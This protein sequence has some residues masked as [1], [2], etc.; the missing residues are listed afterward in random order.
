MTKWQSRV[1]GVVISIIAFVMVI[2]GG[3]LLAESIIHE[4]DVVVT[5]TRIKQDSNTIPAS[6]TVITATDIKEGAFQTVADILCG[7]AG[8]YVSDM[9]GNARRCSVDI[10]GFGERAAANTL[11]LIDGRAINGIDMSGVD[12]TNIPLE[13]IARIEIIRGGASVIYGN[14]AVSGVINIITKKNISK[15]SLATD[16]SYGSYNSYKQSLSL[17]GSFADY[18]YLIDGS[19]NDGDGYRR[20]SYFRNKTA[21]LTLNYMPKEGVFAWQLSAGLKEDAYGLPGALTA[22][23]DPRE[24][25]NPDDYAKTKEQYVHFV[26]SWK[27][28]QNLNFSIE[29]DYREQEQYADFPD[30]VW[31]WTIKSRINQYAISPKFDWYIEQGD[32]VHALTIGADYKMGQFHSLK[33]GT[34]DRHMREIGY[35]VYDKISLSEK[36]YLD[37]GYRRTRSKNSYDKFSKN[38]ANIDSYKAGLTYAYK[39]NS[40]L[41]FSFDRSFRTQLLDELGGPWGAGLP[42]SPQINTQYQLG[43][44]HNFNDKLNTTLSLFQIKTQNEMF[45]NPKIGW[46]G[47]NTSYGTTKRKGVELELQYKPIQTITISTNYT[48][49][50][51]HLKGGEFSG[52]EIPAVPTHTASATINY[53]PTNQFNITLA[54]RWVKSHPSTSDWENNLTPIATYTVVD[55]KAN[56]QLNKNIT[57]Y[58]GVKNIFSEEYEQYVTYGRNLYPAPECN[59][60]VGIKY[61]KEF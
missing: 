23:D 16:I 13:N 39:E 45:F 9:L 18:S 46:A 2:G 42:L 48:Y 26:P 54:G 58:A 30:P 4:K 32:I 6:V 19:Y 1:S 60:F 11:V 22:N 34:D 12:W 44:K 40:K 8:I 37:L 50:N 14:K 43:I 27:I 3:N 5:A 24:S 53:Q 33:N 47:E 52:N 15:H 51:A 35:F 36:L 29:F 56:Y 28:N 17:M 38:I 25:K 55:I 10:R 31:P 61:Y 20:N 49:M 59:Y 41:F 7:R 57:I 21:G